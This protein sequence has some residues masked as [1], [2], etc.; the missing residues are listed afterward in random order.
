M[1]PCD[2]AGSSFNLI[3]AYSVFSH[4]SE[5]AFIAWL[6]EFDRVLKP[7][8]IVALTTRNEGFL[9]YCASLYSKMNELS[10]YQ[11]AL[12]MSLGRDASLKSKYLSGEFVFV[13]D[14]RISGGGSMNESFYG[15]TFI[16]RA[17][18]QEHLVNEFEILDYKQTGRAYDQA[19]FVLKKRS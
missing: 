7:A 10:G 11:L 6:R 15:E 17:Y 16:P 4:L 8:G 1:P 9:D 5:D 19:L 13:S 3:T 14:H 18:V 2:F 12:A